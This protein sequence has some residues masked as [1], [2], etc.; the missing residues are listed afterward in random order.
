MNE[1]AVAP[2]GQPLRAPETRPPDQQQ[3]VR[4]AP[5]NEHAAAPVGQPLR[6]PEGACG[7]AAAGA[8]GGAGGS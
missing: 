4:A 6:A 5:M 8:C 3:A 7:P 1:H 2:V